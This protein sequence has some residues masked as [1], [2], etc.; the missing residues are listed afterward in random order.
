MVSSYPKDYASIIKTNIFSSTKLRFKLSSVICRAIS[1]ERDGVGVGVTYIKQHYNICTWWYI[2]HLKIY[3][4][5][6]SIVMV[7][8]VCNI[9]R[10][11]RAHLGNANEITD[12]G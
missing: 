7:C 11:I 6:L 5:V 2:T 12:Y 8:G 9:P 10:L 3:V 4:H 1:S